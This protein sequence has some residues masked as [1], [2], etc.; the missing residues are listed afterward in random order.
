MNPA[1]LAR[2]ATERIEGTRL[3][4]LVRRCLPGGAI[5]LSVLALT[6]YAMGL[7]RD[8][9]LAH[10]FGAG[11]ELDA[12]NA[13]FILPEL[14]LD[15][16]VAGGLVAPFV[17]L[18]LG[19]RDEAAA[20][21]DRFARTVLGLALGVMAL[22][23][24]VLLALAPATVAVIVPGFNATQKEL[25]VGLFRV[26]CLTPPIFAASLVVGEVLVARRRFLWYGLAPLMYS[27]G[28]AAGALVLSGPLGRLRRGVGRGGGRP[29]PPRRQADRAAGHGLPA[30]AGLRPA[31]P[32]SGRVPAPHAPQDGEPAARAARLPLL[33]EPRVRP[34]RGLG[35]LAQLRAQLLRRPGEP[36]RDVVRHRRVPGPVRGRQCRRPGR[37]RAPLPADAARDGPPLAARR[38]RAVRPLRARD[39]LLP[40]GRGV[41]RRG[42]RPNL[43]GALRL[44]PRGAARERHERARARRVRHAQHDPADARRAHGIRRRGGYGA[45]VAAE[46]GYRR[47]PRLVRGR[48]GRADAA[49]GRH[50]GGARVGDLA[51]GRRRRSAPAGG[52][53]APGHP[54]EAGAGGHGRGHRGRPGGHGRRHWAGAQLR[55]PRG[56]AGRHAVGA[57]AAAGLAQRPVAAADARP[58][59]DRVDRV[60]RGPERFAQRHGQSCPDARAHPRGAGPSRSRWTSTS[61]ATSSASTWTCGA[62]PPRSR[63]RSTS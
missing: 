62:C 9:V 61:A 35:E 59:A 36:H 22:T 51:C 10:T 39:R 52:A 40:Q 1:T 42:R 31:D 57:R 33:H 26:M 27:G 50:P 28:I 48:D 44:R 19:L 41:R 47:D 53:R 58:R 38:R 25:Y 14:A 16:V 56:R 46:P 63:P 30:G 21:A 5:T 6:G 34:R 32:R 15:V 29:R 45:G 7:G 54:D 37:V 24:L 12:Y 4:A 60:N 17:P 8:K 13:A 2:R 43:A 23:S 11:A 18:F 3:A 49:A 20:E 55:D